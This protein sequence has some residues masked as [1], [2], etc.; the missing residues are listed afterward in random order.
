MSDNYF[1]SSLIAA[2][3]IAF[4]PQKKGSDRLKSVTTQGNAKEYEGL[5]EEIDFMNDT[6][7]DI[8]SA[9]AEQEV[10]VENQDFFH[11]ACAEINRY[12]TLDRLIASYHNTITTSCLEVCSISSGHL[13]IS[14]NHLVSFLDSTALDIKRFTKG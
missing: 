9:E 8:A 7:D 1:I 12:L 11:E 10:P 6:E 5:V 13:L 3:C 14:T 4:L 2:L